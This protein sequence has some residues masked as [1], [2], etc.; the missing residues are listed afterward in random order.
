MSCFHPIPAWYGRGFTAKGKREIVFSPTLGYSDKQFLLPCG[1]CDG[2]HLERARQWAIRC[3]HESE[4]YCANCFITLTYADEFLPVRGVCVRD[5]QLFMKR[6]RKSIGTAVRY[7]HCGEYGEKFSRAHYHALLFG[8]DFPDKVFL[9][10]RRGERVFLSQMLTDLW[11]KGK[12]E[13]GSVTI[14]SASYVARYCL[15]K[16]NSNCSSGFYVDSDGVMSNP[17]YV[18]MSRRPGIGKGWYDKYKGDVFPSDS[19]IVNGV[20]VRPPK[21]YDRMYDIEN[22]SDFA[23]IKAARAPGGTPQEKA[24]EFFRLPVKE[25]VCKSRLKDFNRNLEG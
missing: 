7:F 23:R 3:M 14:R 25:I 20:E 18:T 11:G 4:L 6:L 21:F 16:V 15:K 19:V 5:F 13:V 9:K 10:V 22:P 17:E 2:C 8:Y 12:T 1:S 24:V